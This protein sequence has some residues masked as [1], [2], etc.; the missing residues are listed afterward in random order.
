MNRTTLISKVK[1]FAVNALPD[2][3]VID[4]SE[5]PH[6]AAR[7]LVTYWETE[8]AELGETLDNVDADDLDEYREACVIAVATRIFESRA[9]A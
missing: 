1:Q 8:A 5:E 4:A 9:S 7:N 6:E 3:S 2:T